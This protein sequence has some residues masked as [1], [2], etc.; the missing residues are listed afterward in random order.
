LS[1]TKS[2]TL[3]VDISY[4]QH[5]AGVLNESVLAISSR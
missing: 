2:R 1:K 3:K 4:S 5:C